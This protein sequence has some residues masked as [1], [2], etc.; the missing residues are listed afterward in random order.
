MLPF[1]EGMFGVAE[2]GNDHRAS[3]PA[4]IPN[5]NEISSGDQS[6]L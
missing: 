5:E 6:Q 4:S 2:P 3:T 1:P